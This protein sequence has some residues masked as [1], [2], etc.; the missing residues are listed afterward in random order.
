MRK[1]SPAIVT[2]L[3]DILAALPP[4]RR[5]KIEARAAEILH[6]ERSHLARRR[7]TTRKKR[8]SL[9]AKNPPRAPHRS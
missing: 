3:D 6:E 8:S 7:A 5:A 4:A 2:N 9:A 1:R